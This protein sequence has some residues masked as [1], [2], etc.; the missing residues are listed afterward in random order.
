MSCHDKWAALHRNRS[1]PQLAVYPC[2]VKNIVRDNY[3]FL[4]GT[5]WHGAVAVGYGVRLISCWAFVDE[6]RFSM[7]IWWNR[8]LVWP[9]WTQSQAISAIFLGTVVGVLQS[10]HNCWCWCP[11]YHW[12]IGCD[13]FSL[14]PDSQCFWSKGS[15][16][17]Q[18]I[19][20][21][22]S[23]AVLVCRQILLLAQF[24]LLPN[25]WRIFQ[26]AILE[27]LFGG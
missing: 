9:I 19:S 26:L 17:T 20:F 23:S 22:A 15:A 2:S 14:L 13:L 7:C 18:C 21:C 6:G 5:C 4:D 12:T 3:R 1:H 10:G 27:Y 16:I 8:C 11:A 25:S 24:V